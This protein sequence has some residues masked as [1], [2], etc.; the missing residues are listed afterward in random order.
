MYKLIAF[1]FDGTIADTIP[2]CIEAFQNSASSY[3]GHKLTR[4]EI[5]RTFGL[6]ETG[7]MKVLVGEKWDAALNDFYT[8]YELLHNKIT[9]PFENIP[10]L[11]H[12]LKQEKIIVALITG[13]GEKSCQISLEKLGLTNT[14]DEVLCGSEKAPNKKERMEYLIS[15]YQI[16]KEQ[17]CYV[18]DTKEDIEACQE[19]GVTCLSAAWQKS[20]LSFILEE[21]N[22]HH[23]FY[24]VEDLFPYFLSC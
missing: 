6:T 4:E 19:L 20:S 12:F 9:K 2:L 23:V 10:R 18:G 21:K 1:D 7:M 8:E 24:H 3:A 11:L 14:F 22:P 17:F 5:S 15:R 16:P 13:K